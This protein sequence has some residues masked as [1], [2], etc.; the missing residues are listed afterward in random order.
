MALAR[1]FNDI[2][3]SKTETERGPAYVLSRPGEGQSATLSEQQ[4][5][6]AKLLGAVHTFDELVIEARKFGL[7][8][9]EP[10]A[11]KFVAGLRAR[12]LIGDALPEAQAPAPAAAAPAVPERPKLRSDLEVVRKQN[13]RA[14]VYEVRA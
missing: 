5:R 1:L 11:Q 13:G 7:G 2:Q 3:V 6:L 14:I 12:Q 8:I 4:F 9:T 10:V